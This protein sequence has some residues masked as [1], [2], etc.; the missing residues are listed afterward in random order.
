[1]LITADQIIFWLPCPGYPNYR[2]HQLVPGPGL[3]PLEI[4]AL[5][6]PPE[7]RVWVLLRPEVLGEHGFQVALD[8]IVTRVVTN[9]ALHCGVPEVE[10]WAQRWLDGTD[11]T[12]AAACSAASAAWTEEQEAAA[13]AAK[14]AAWAAA[15]AA[16]AAA[17]AAEAVA[18]AARSADAAARAAAAGATWAAERILQLCD[19]V[20]ILEGRR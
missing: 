19:I 11:R 20:H 3:T 17:W 4:A 7:D 13:R 10:L 18:W 9:H 14:M 16:R 12:G 15:E 5:L 8:R 6:I 2:V 1:M